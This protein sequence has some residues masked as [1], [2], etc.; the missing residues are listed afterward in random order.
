[1]VPTGQ[2]WLPD[3]SKWYPNDP[4]WLP[5]GLKFLPKGPKWLPIGP[6]W[7]PNGLKRF[8]SG[9]K[10]FTNCS[11]CSHMIPNDFQI[12]Q[13][14]S[15]KVSNDYHNGPKLSQRHAKWSK[16]V[17][18]DWTQMILKL[19][20]M[21]L[22]FAKRFPNISISLANKLVSMTQI[23]PKWMIS[24][25]KWLPNDPSV[26]QMVTIGFKLLAEL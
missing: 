3:S 10:W 24:V 16:I 22:N 5:N 11:K 6:K 12:I 4:K 20:E 23:F 21:T 26:E 1:M 13:K 19:L 18:N 9:H 14:N 2:K 25:P 8:P 15:Q 7:F 17:P